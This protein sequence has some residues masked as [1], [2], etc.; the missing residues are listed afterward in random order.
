[1]T[2]AIAVRSRSLTLAASVYSLY[3]LMAVA[4]TAYCFWLARAMLHSNQQDGAA[5]AVSLK[6]GSLFFAFVAIIYGVVAAGL[7]RSARWAWWLGL[8]VNVA[9]IAA[10]VSDAASGD[11][12]PDGWTALALFAAPMVFLL[13]PSVR[14]SLASRKARPAQ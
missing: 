9:V 2:S 14:R 3:A 13:V 4:G 11:R 8:I 1:M 10:I 5:L 12:D 6:I 7:W